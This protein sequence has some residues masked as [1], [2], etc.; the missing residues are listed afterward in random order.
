[1]LATGSADESW[2]LQSLGN[3]PEALAV[4]TAFLENPL[5]VGAFAQNVDMKHPKIASVPIGLDFHTIAR[6]ELAEAH[7][8]GAAVSVPAQEAELLRLRCALPPFSARP[9]AAVMN[10]KLAGR[11]IR[12]HVHGLLS[13]Q[14]G[15]EWVD[16]MKRADMWRS[17][18]S[19][20][21]VVSPRGYGNDCHRTWEALALG[22]A[23]IVKYDEF[24]A[25]L[26]EDL[27]V[28]QVR[29]WEDVTTERLA[30]WK[31][32]LVARWHTFRFE[33]VRAAY[34]ESVVR[35]AAREH[36]MASIWKWSTNSYNFSATEFAWGKE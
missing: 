17:Y 9:L 31:A 11:G 7:A 35:A 22:T 12:N 18:G 13:G 10:F 1:V 3:T 16:D 34:W 14:P 5:F 19:Y 26:F 25:P 8:W 23:V 32:D 29:F 20:S 2:P 36:F 21:F 30:Q 33:K 15:F 28:I 6:P 4:A 24:L 27:P